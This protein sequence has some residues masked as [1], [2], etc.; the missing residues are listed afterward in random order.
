MGWTSKKTNKQAS[1]HVNR[2]Y[3]R[4]KPGHLVPIEL[5][6]DA[7]VDIERHLEL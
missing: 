7:S 2:T 5:I 6:V 1:V 4:L 3:L